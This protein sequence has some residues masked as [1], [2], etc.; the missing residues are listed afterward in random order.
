M[1][2]PRRR[3]SR[4]PA[5]G[6]TGMGMNATG[7]EEFPLSSSRTKSL[8]FVAVSVLKSLVYASEARAPRATI[9]FYTLT[10]ACSVLPST[11]KMATRFQIPAGAGSMS[12]DVLSTRAERIS[13]V[14]DSLEKGL[15]TLLGA[16]V[17]FSPGTAK[18]LNSLAA[19]KETGRR[20]QFITL[21]DERA[22]PSCTVASD[23]R[24]HVVS[25]GTLMAM[26]KAEI[27]QRYK[28][29]DTTALLDETARE[30]LNVMAKQVAESLRTAL[31]DPRADFLRQ[32]FNV[33]GKLPRATMLVLKC[34][35]EIAGSPAGQVQI[36]L[37]EALVS[38][39][40]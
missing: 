26:T 24:F 22:V 6:P 14:F 38:R 31:R 36:W 25:A 1:S 5:S 7:M 35:A 37:L 34:D 27:D 40:K 29:E 20:S 3:G 23:F 17:G 21:F 28:M 16:P 2:E 13:A 30:V 18:F 15:G 33:T 39:I 19:F 10:A 4:E 12:A 11:R 8:A 32:E 9:A